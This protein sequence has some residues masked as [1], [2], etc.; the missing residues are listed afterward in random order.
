MKTLNTL[1][2][3]AVMGLGLP[4]AAHAIVI[5]S[6]FDNLSEKEIGYTPI[7]LDQNF[8][9]TIDFVITNDTGITWTDFHMS[10]SILFNP[11]GPYAYNG[12]GT[13]IWSTD[14]STIDIIGLEILDG[15]DFQFSISCVGSC[16]LA[17][18]TFN[19]YPT[20]DSGGNDNGTPGGTSVPEP[21]TLFLLGPGIL[22][23]I[24][25]RRRRKI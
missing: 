24:A 3:V 12:T 23:L 16:S 2:I 5:A 7:E 11:L 20:I 25:I 4:T 21:S 1:L 6:T 10:Q 9:P 22:G 14:Y 18:M 13:E 17:G 19:G 15:Y 8:D